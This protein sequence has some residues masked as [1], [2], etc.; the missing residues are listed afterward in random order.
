MAIDWDPL[1]TDGD[2]FPAEPGEVEAYGQDLQRTAELIGDQV[3]L[4]R[5]L[6][7]EDSWYTDAADA[8]REKAEELADR[9]TKVK[10]RYAE[11][12]GHLV[13]F[14][15]TVRVKEEAAVRVRDAA[16]DHEATLRAN[17][18]VEPGHAPPGEPAPEL[19]AGQ[20]AQNRRHDAA[21]SALDH[22]QQEFDGLVDAARSAASACAGRISGAIKDDVK[23]DWWDRNAGWL[24]T[25]TKV[26]GWV[27]TIAAIVLL[28]VGT[29]GLIWAVALGVGLAAGLISLAINVGLA[30]NADGG[31][32]AVV[33]DAIGVLTLGAGGLFAKIGSK[34]F[35]ALRAATASYRSEQAAAATMRSFGIRVPIAR[36]FASRNIPLVSR[37]ASGRLAS[38]SDEAARAGSAAYDAVMAARTVT[39]PQRLLNGGK[40]AAQQMVV[41]RE[42][43]AGLRAT[44]G[45]PTALVQGLTSLSRVN[46]AATVSGLAGL[47]NT[48]VKTAVSDGPNDTANGLVDIAVDVL[49]RMFR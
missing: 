1:A 43:L 13:V 20:K 8:F 32:S 33:F 28:T 29:G 49:P 9:I 5:K 31:W 19:T 37:F 44:S 36:F 46:L 42:L 21:S 35:P 16:R 34:A 39:V 47:G 4:L 40:S 26:L 2:P 10:D 27:V 11:T 48:V 24:K 12:G 45:A 15:E 6:A 17:P 38:M 22:L 23:D 25:I 3:T 18:V 14:A 7:Q 30:R 41:T